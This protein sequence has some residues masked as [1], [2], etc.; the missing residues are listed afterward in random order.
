M[1]QNYKYKG[2]R[3]YQKNNYGFKEKLNYSKAIAIYDVEGNKAKKTMSYG[4]NNKIIL[5]STLDSETNNIDGFYFQDP[6][7]DP[8]DINQSVNNKKLY[9]DSDGLYYYN[10]IDQ[11]QFQ[12]WDTVGW[13]RNDNSSEQKDIYYF[14]N[15]NYESSL[16]ENFPH[17]YSTPYTNFST[18][19]AIA[20][21]H[22]QYTNIDKI[23]LVIIESA[24]IPKG[25][26]TPIIANNKEIIITSQHP[27]INSD[28]ED[29]KA[30]LY[31]SGE[32]TWETRLYC[33]CNISFYNL[34][35]SL[36]DISGY[37]YAS[38]TSGVGTW[39]FAQN[40][41]LTLGRGLKM[42]VEDEDIIGGSVYNSNNLLISAIKMYIMGGYECPRNDTLLPRAMFS[43]TIRI[44][45]GS[46]WFVGGWNKKYKPSGGPL[47]SE[48]IQQLMCSEEGTAISL[49][50]G[51]NANSTDEVVEIDRVAAF[52]TGPQY[53]DKES[54]VNIK[55]LSNI[56]IRVLHPLNQNQ[57][58]AY[59]N[60][61]YF[62]T[63][64][65]IDSNEGQNINIITDEGN[66]SKNTIF[67]NT[68]DTN[69]EYLRGK[70]YT[71]NERLNIILSNKFDGNGIEIIL[72][73]MEKGANII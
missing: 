44:E 13:N 30:I 3:L 16:N 52:S 65:E 61:G 72:N 62:I 4:S 66:E 10:E 39:I 18:A 60:N 22:L 25:Y 58:E 33:N 8:L 46:Y 26:S 54:F 63:T 15:E 7:Y 42:E 51:N 67:N 47:I 6:I 41:N 29:K 14:I 64:L 9:G 20:S 32:D 71:N 70:I 11:L 34:I 50:L 27:N 21:L 68:I 55:I 73:N 57:I 43:S 2:A 69:N 5:P 12:S 38:N 45:S 40:H 36:K 59:Y 56:H 35:F 24:S 19:F 23:T 28:L 49:Y 17:Y 1:T 37:G 48:A 53:L 31:F